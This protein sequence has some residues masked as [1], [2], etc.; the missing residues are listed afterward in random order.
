MNRYSRLEINLLPREMLPGPAVRYALMVNILICLAALAYILVD[1]GMTWQW[2]QSKAEERDVLESRVTRQIGILED[3]ERLDGMNRRLTRYGRLIALASY[4]YVDM[5]V[6]LTR[7]A[8]II[9]DG[10]YLDSVHN[11]GADAGAIRLS[12]V[13][14]TSKQD[15]QQVLSTL[16]AFK[17]DS[18]FADCYMPNAA[19]KEEA[20]DE[21]MERVGVTWS[22]SGPEAPGSIIAYQYDFEIQAA[23]PRPLIG[24]NLPVEY[25][26]TVYFTRLRLGP[27]GSPP[28]DAPGQPPEGVTVEEVF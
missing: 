20:L 10:V 5:P 19:Y 27:A 3:Y 2:L 7:L 15:P 9:P 13:L 28:T 18:I 25:D 6:I 4:D 21:L 8:E 23:L 24:L 16:R 1:A 22:V 17:T 26:D 14:K 11:R 12:T